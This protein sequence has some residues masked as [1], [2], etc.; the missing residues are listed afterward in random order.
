[1]IRKSVYYFLLLIVGTVSVVYILTF[2]LVK[3]IKWGIH[4]DPALKIP[5]AVIL[6]LL[7]M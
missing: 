2:I 3:G 5:G 7:L 1:M 4:M 6:D